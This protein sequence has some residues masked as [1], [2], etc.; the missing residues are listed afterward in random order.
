MDLFAYFCSLSSFIV[1]KLFSPLN[2]YL[3]MYA[4]RYIVRHFVSSLNYCLMT[5]A[6]LA[7]TV[8]FWILRSA[9]L[10]TSKYLYLSCPYFFSRAEGVTSWKSP[11]LEN[12]KNWILPTTLKDE[13]HTNRFFLMTTR[14]CIMCFL[15]FV[16]SGVVFLCPFLKGAIRQNY[17]GTL[18]PQH[19]QAYYLYLCMTVLGMDQSKY[20]FNNSRLKSDGNMYSTF[21]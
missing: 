19:P 7:V 11:W 1:R 18:P 2:E 12:C 9:Y 21:Q 8:R 6:N 4:S 20:T 13:S 14:L 17:F 15:T 3:S 10:Y 16:R 5:N